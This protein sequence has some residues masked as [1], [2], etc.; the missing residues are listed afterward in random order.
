[1]V[2]DPSPS[3]HA[4]RKAVR[5]GGEG[6][7]Q[8]FWRWFAAAFL[9]VLLISGSWAMANPLGAAPDEGAHA[10]TAYATAHGDIG[11]V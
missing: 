8:L 7:G 5:A 1:M 10:V 9:A 11:N 2:P 3:T 6:E 4:L